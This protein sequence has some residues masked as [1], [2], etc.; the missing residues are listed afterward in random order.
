MRVPMQDSLT[1]FMSGTYVA[2]RSPTTRHGLGY[3]MELLKGA[4]SA[5]R[6]N[7]CERPE[8]GVLVTDLG[9]TRGLPVDVMIIGGMEDGLIPGQNEPQIFLEQ[10][11]Q[12]S[13]TEA[14]PRSHPFLGRQATGRI[15]CI[16]VSA[17]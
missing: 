10:P 15:N 3:Y 12:R 4:I 5:E 9:E 13:G 16:Y 1:Y 11:F 7:F 14:S 17:A 8:R 2:A 6:Y